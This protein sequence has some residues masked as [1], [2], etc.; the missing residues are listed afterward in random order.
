VQDETPLYWRLAKFV[1]VGVFGSGVG[2]AIGLVWNNFAELVSNWMRHL[3]SAEKLLALAVDVVGWFMHKVGVLLPGEVGQT[4]QTFGDWIASAPVEK[5]V[6]VGLYFLSPFVSPS[7]VSSC[8]AVILSAWTF[9][10]LVKLV[11]WVT[12]LFWTQPT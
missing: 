3:F 2:A 1:I 6:N 4:L 7:L 10:F 9:A 8:L 11:M 12:S 5:A